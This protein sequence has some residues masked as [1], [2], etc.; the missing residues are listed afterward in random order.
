MSLGSLCLVMFQLVA[1]QMMFICEGFATYF[2]LVWSFTSMYSLML[3]KISALCKGLGTIRALEGF[4]T[5]V[6][7][8][9]LVQ[10][11]FTIKLFATILAGVL[12]AILM[13]YRIGAN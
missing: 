8:K 12:F 4:L 11:V 2:T 7:S 10:T 9:V 1:V 5:C 13:D 3:G 6:S